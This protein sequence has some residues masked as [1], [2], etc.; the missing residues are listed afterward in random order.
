MVAAALFLSACSTM[1][2][3]D[4]YDASYD[5]S[6]VKRFAVVHK[7]KAGENPLVAKRIEE[8]LY[9]VL[10][11]KGF[12]PSDPKNADL[13]FL[14]HTDVT[15]KTQIYTDY[16]MV[17]YGRYGAMVVSSPRSYN[18]EEGRLIVDAYDPKRNGVVYRSEVID[19]LRY[20]KTPQE[21]RRYID[22]VIT[23]ALE[24]FPPKGM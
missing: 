7:P 17:G 6:K 16:Q 5:F 11:R 14:F 21:R 9:K 15:N 24:N 4:D 20:K 19:E 3:R 8:A 23:E 10:E 12:K 1:Q 18:Y 2:I 13:V 22:A